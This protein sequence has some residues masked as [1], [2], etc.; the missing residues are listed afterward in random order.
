MT[1]LTA[2]QHGEEGNSGEEEDGFGGADAG[3]AAPLL[4]RGRGGEAGGRRAC[5]ARSR[6]RRRGLGGGVAAAALLREEAMR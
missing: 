5:R 1:L 6:G 3:A 4:S 2:D